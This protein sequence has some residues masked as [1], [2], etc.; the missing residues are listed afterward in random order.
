MKTKKMLGTIC[1]SGLLEICSTKI[2]NTEMHF[3][4]FNNGFDGEKYESTFSFVYKDDRDL[5]I[6]F[7]FDEIEIQRTINILKK[8]L[9]NNRDHKKL[10]LNEKK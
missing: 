5:S 4:I 8:H 10:V 6:D 9:K 1:H 3:E 7:Y 2:K